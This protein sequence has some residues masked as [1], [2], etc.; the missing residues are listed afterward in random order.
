MFSRFDSKVVE[1][2]YHKKYLSLFIFRKLFSAE[3]AVSD[4][5]SLQFYQKRTLAK[6]FFSCYLAVP[7]PTLGHYRGGSLTHAMLITAFLQVQP[8]G[9]CKTCNKVGSLSPANHLVG[10]ELEPILITMP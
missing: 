7:R 6:V 4:R 8:E 1:S 10:F 2:N 5:G 9:H 3:S